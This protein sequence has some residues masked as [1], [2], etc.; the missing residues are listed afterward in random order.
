MELCEVIDAIRGC[1]SI[2]DGMQEDV[3]DERLV[4]VMAA[5]GKCADALLAIDGD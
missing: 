2:L 5:L 1:A 4:A 3:A